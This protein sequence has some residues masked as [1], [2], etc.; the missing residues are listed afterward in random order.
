[1]SEWIYRA[2]GASNHHPERREVNDYYATD[3]RAIDGLLSVEVFNGNVWEAACGGGHLVDRL[4]HYGYNVLAT[5]LIDRGQ[6]TFPLDF[7]S[8]DAGAFIGRYDIITNP[9]YGLALEFCQQ[10]LD[11]TRGKVAMFLKLQFLE[12]QKRRKFFLETPPVRVWVYSWRIQCAKNG[13]FNALK[14]GS[15][16]SFA[17]F[18]WEKG[19]RGAPQIGWL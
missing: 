10:A 15:P 18:V 16:Q 12:G 11:L 3:P 5:D 1:M 14:N 2:L 19:F 13:D 8:D 17:W 9:P 7:L 6:E 4:R